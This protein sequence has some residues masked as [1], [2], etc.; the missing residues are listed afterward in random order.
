MTILLRVAYDGTH[1]CGYQI[2]RSDRT[3]QGELEAALE[4]LLGEPV[5]TVCAGRTDTGVHALGQYVSFSAPSSRI[6]PVSFAPALN[7]ILPDDV[8][9]VSSRLVPDDFHAQ[10]SARQRHYRYYLYAAPVILPHRRRYAWRIPQFPSLARMNRDAE[11]L[12][13]TRDFSAFA[14]L[15]GEQRSTVR[16]VSYARFQPDRDEG[17]EFCIGAT[18]F[19]RRMV[20]SIVGTLVERERLRLRGQEVTTPLEEILA[21]GDRRGAGTTAPPWGLFLYDV[22][23]DPD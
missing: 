12:V 16:T 9:V 17:L 14:M 21:R 22:D 8:S 6:E 15:G 18:G 7:S 10:Y 1:F 11:A 23:Y 19:L 20:R 3:V 2:Q 5:R 13:G 4:R